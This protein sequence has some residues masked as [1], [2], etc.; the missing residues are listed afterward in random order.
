MPGARSGLTRDHPRSR[1]VYTRRT[2]CHPGCSWIIP[3]RAGFTPS[4]RRPSSSGWDHPR[5]RG[6]YAAM[7]ASRPVCIGSS[8]LARGLPDSRGRPVLGERI[9]PARAGFTRL[10]PGSPTPWTDHPRS[11]GVYR[12]CGSRG[13]EFVGSSPLARGLP[14]DVGPP[15]RATAYH[16]RSRGVYGT[17][18]APLIGTAGSSP[19]A[20]GLRDTARPTHRHRR[21]I[22]ARAGF[23]L[24][25]CH[26]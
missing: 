22:P 4:G 2:R 18:L 21:I 10:S 9:I 20:R 5:S 26:A 25:P 24:G 6:V 23:T 7:N 15:S 19:L 16:P 17:P 3:A 12:Y 14:H 1:G 11:R 8:P 13:V